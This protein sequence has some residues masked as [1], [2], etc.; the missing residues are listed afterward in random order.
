MEVYQ[1][2]PRHRYFGRDSVPSHR[3][4]V[5]RREPRGIRTTV[6]IVD[7]MFEGA[8]DLDG[9]CAREQLNCGVVDESVC[10][11]IPDWIADSIFER[12]APEGKIDN[13]VDQE[14]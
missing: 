10:R 2:L 13:Q 3:F 5:L 12:T 7:R 6:Y 8:R 9:L 14:K 4:Q 1:R 11:S